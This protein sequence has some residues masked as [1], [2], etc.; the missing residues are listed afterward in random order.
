M[1]AKRI[2][3][4]ILMKNGLLVKGERFKA[5]RVCGNALQAARV[6]AMR[7]VDEI[8]ML[9]VDAGKSEKGPNL[10]LVEQLTRFATVPV[11]IGGGI[12]STGWV[13]DLLLAGADRVCISDDWPL[14]IREIAERWGSQVVTV[15]VD[16]REMPSN[17]PTSRAKWAEDEGAGEIILQSIER[18]GTMKGYDLEMIETVSKAVNIPV[19]ASSGC[20]GYQDMHDAII[21][22][23]DAVAA[24]ALFQFTNATPRG[25]AE[26]LNEQGVE[27][28]L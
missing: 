2:I 14:L 26:Y 18:D 7:Q 5:D 12:N 15:T 11:T 10:Q 21:A 6:H 1:L 8:L 23:A 22:G 17:V 28:R 19:V 13:S 25:A 9:D 4:T 27:V 24:G 20:K 3:P 16:Y